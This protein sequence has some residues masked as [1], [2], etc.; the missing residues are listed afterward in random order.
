MDQNVVYNPLRYTN[1]RKKYVYVEKEA[2]PMC[3]K[4]K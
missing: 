3:S 1:K 2:F 4:Y